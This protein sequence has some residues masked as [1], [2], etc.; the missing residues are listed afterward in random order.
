MIT[1]FEARD[2]Q[3]PPEIAE[4]IRGTAEDLSSIVMSHVAPIDFGV[5]V[6]ALQARDDEAF[7]AAVDSLI[8][9]VLPPIIRQT[10]EKWSQLGRPSEQ[11]ELTGSALALLSS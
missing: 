3:L 6:A 8:R 2:H 9:G 7:G 11:S 10:T 4:A 5:L 1:G